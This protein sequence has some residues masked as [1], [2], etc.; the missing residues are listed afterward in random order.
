MLFSSTLLAEFVKEFGDTV[1]IFIEEGV[2]KSPVVQLIV[3]IAAILMLLSLAYTT[4]QKKTNKYFIYFFVAWFLALPINGKPLIYNIVNSVSVTFSYELQKLTYDLFTKVGT[5]NTM[6]PDFV[7]NSIMRASTM[8]VDDPAVKQDVLFVLDNCIPHGTNKNGLPISGADLFSGKVTQLNGV[9]AV[10]FNFEPK[11]LNNRKFQVDGNEVNCFDLVTSTLHALRNN[12]RSQDP[13]K[14]PPTLY[15]GSNNG[16]ET[17]NRVTTWDYDGSKEPERVKRIALNLAQ[18]NAIQSL[19]LQNF[20]DVELDYK[21]KGWRNSEAMAP[22][23]MIIKK[24]F[25]ERDLNMLNIWSKFSLNFQ[26]APKAFARYFNLGGRSEVAQALIEINEKQ[27]SLPYYISFTQTLLKIIIP[28]IVLT[29][30]FG[31]FKW[32]IVWSSTWFLTLIVPS[33]LYIQR[34]ITNSILLHVNRIDETSQVLASDPAFLEYGVDFHAAVQMLEDTSR[35]M[36]VF[37]KCESAL[38]GILFMAIP[39]AA[40]LASGKIESFGAKAIGFVT[41]SIGSGLGFG[42]GSHYARKLFGGGINPP[43]PPTPNLS[44]NSNVNFN[45][46]D[47]GA[48]QFQNLTA[49]FSPPQSEPSQPTNKD[50]IT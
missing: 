42:I 26:Q 4:S 27:Y 2:Y 6:P 48:N 46:S 9:D 44:G 39:G 5:R 22:E 37:L 19:V 45:A 47:I 34:L 43:T 33:I 41:Q 35:A 14:M 50:N 10:A 25:M 28:L 16:E 3:Y 17:P 23:T 29:G 21:G 7:L 15:V 11:L 8:T 13:T 32:I 40:W 30:F 12:L 49:S 18:A 20:F 24:N 38:W 1:L 36:S 31:T